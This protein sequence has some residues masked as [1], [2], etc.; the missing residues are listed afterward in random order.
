MLCA[1]N[2]V[3]K[4]LSPGLGDVIRQDSHRPVSGAGSARMGRMTSE[5]PDATHSGAEPN[6]AGPGLEPN[7]PTVRLL[8]D[9]QGIG[10]ARPRGG[11]R[12]GPRPD[13]YRLLASPGILEGLARRRRFD[14]DPNS[15]LPGRGARRQPVRPGLVSGPR[16]RR[17]GRR[18]AGARD[19]SGWV[20]PSTAASRSCQLVHD[21]GQRRARPIEQVFNGW[22]AWAKGATWSFGNA[23]EEDGETLLPWLQ[24]ALGAGLSAGPEREAEPTGRP[25]AS[26]RSL[27]TQQVAFRRMMPQCPS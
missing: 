14:V 27:R 19:W 13:R 4:L 11:A 23:Y 22:T 26:H 2:G 10:P 21:P 12:R 15:H 6:Q 8:A 1:P 5:T 17:P 9:A 24:E 16:P 20:A 25:Q 7:Q 18:R 3:P